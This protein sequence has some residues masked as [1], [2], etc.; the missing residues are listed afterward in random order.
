ML[1][2]ENKKYA[3]YG[4][5]GK[6]HTPETIQKMKDWHIKAGHDGSFMRRGFKQISLPDGKARGEHRIIAETALGRK[7]VTDEVVHHIN[8]I[9]DDNRNENL[10]ICT[11]GYH[12]CLHFKMSEAWMKEHLQNA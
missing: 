3:T 2:P 11:R 10:L 12:T 8:G 4:F 6:K 5:A 1:R 9:K 7:L